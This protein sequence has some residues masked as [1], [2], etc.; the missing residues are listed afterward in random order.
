MVAL[1]TLRVTTE[2][3]PIIDLSP[4]L[5]PGSINARAPT[6]AFLPI[7]IHAV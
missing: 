4:I 6:K 1:G 3:A 7:E 5:T 2:Q